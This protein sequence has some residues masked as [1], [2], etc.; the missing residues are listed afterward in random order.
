MQIVSQSATLEL[1]DRGRKSDIAPNRSAVGERPRDQYFVTSTGA[2]RLLLS[3]VIVARVAR[4]H[5]VRYKLCPSTYRRFAA[6]FGLGEE[7]SRLA[8]LET[9]MSTPT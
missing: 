3:I 2:D 8:H 4:S 9:E 5:V 7:P 6:A 1:G